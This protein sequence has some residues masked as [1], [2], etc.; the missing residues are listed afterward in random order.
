MRGGIDAA[1]VVVIRLAPT[2]SHCGLFAMRSTTHEAAAHHSEMVD[3][4][5]RL[6]DDDAK[7]STTQAFALPH[8][9]GAWSQ[10][11]DAHGNKK[12][13]NEKVRALG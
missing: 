4:L 10:E 6:T 11:S 2:V 13:R 8:L 12:W 5:A 7:C 9:A 3:A 1:M